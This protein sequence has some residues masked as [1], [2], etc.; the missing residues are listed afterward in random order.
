M[1]I[2]GAD[3]CPRRLL[4]TARPRMR[5]GIHGVRSWWHRLSVHLGNRSPRGRGGHCWPGGAGIRGMAAVGSEGKAGSGRRQRRLGAAWGRP[6]AA[7]PEARRRRGWRGRRPPAALPACGLEMWK[8]AREG[9]QHAILTHLHFQKLT[10]KIWRAVCFSFL[11]LFSPSRG[12]LE[13]S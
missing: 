7:A 6:R 1:Q 10:D 3:I 4:P 11:Y 8:S 9:A 12:R 5:A 2:T 13:I